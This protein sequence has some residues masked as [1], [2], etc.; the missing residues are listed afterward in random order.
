MTMPPE[1]QQSP[2]DGKE[3]QAWKNKKK[4]KNKKQGQGQGQGQEGEEVQ[5]QGQSPSPT[6]SQKKGQVNGM[7]HH[8]SSNG[9]K[10]QIA[11]SP[12]SAPSPVASAS[13]S[14]TPT[15]A[16]PTE[17]IVNSVDAPLSKSAA[18]RQRK[19]AKIATAKQGQAHSNGASDHEQQSAQQK[20]G[21]QPSARPIS[22]PAAAD[23]VKPS[24][25]QQQPPKGSTSNSQPQASKERKEMENKPTPQTARPA[26]SAVSASQ[27]VA[28]TSSTTSPAPSIPSIRLSQ[29]T[30]PMSSCASVRPAFASHSL[31]TANAYVDMLVNWLRD[32]A[33]L[34]PDRL[35]HHHSH[36]HAI[37]KCYVVEMSAGLNHGKF[38]YQFMMQLSERVRELPMAGEM[39]SVDPNVRSSPAALLAPLSSHFTYVL[40]DPDQSRLDNLRLHP[41]LQALMEMGLMDV[42]RLDPTNPRAFVIAAPAALAAGAQQQIGVE[43]HLQHSGT[44]LT[45]LDAT[46]PLLCICNEQM[47]LGQPAVTSTAAP[48]A[49]K[50][51]KG[52]LHA[53]VGSCPWKF[54]GFAFEQSSSGD[55]AKDTLTEW[56]VHVEPHEQHVYPNV[57]WQQKSIAD[58]STYYSTPE[59]NRVLQ[60]AVQRLKQVQLPHVAVNPSFPAQPVFVD[61]LPPRSTSSNSSTPSSQ[62]FTLPITAFELLRSLR[63]FARGPLLL[64]MA[65][66]AFTELVTLPAQKPSVGFMR[67][68][69]HTAPHPMPP[70]VPNMHSLTWLA[71]EMGGYALT[72][73]NRSVS[74]LKLVAVGFTAAPDASNDDN[75]DTD[76]VILPVP[77]LTTSPSKSLLKSP[78]DSS[79]PNSG[80][81]AKKHVQFCGLS[82][83]EQKLLRKAEKARRQERLAVAQKLAAERSSGRPRF[84][85]APVQLRSA[86]HRHFCI[87]SAFDL[88]NVVSLCLPSV[89]ISEN[90]AAAAD[91]RLLQSGL[92]LLALAQHDPEIW[93]KLKAIFSAPVPKQKGSN[94]QQKQETK[95]NDAAATSTSTSSSESVTSTAPTYFLSSPMEHDLFLALTRVWRNFFALPSDIYGTLSGQQNV[96]LAF[97]LGS[98]YCIRR[99]FRTAIAY[100]MRSLAWFGRHAVTLFNLA[101][102]HIHLREYDAA[103][104]LMKE[105]LQL[106]PHGTQAQEWMKWLDC[107]SSTT[108]AATSASAMD[109][110]DVDKIDAFTETPGELEDD[111]ERQ[112][113][114][115]HQQQQQKVQDAQRH[116]EQTQAVNASHSVSAIATDAATDNA[117]SNGSVAIAAQPAQPP[118]EQQQKQLPRKQPFWEKRKQLKEARKAAAAAASTSSGPAHTGSSTVAASPSTSTQPSSASAQ[119]SV[120]STVSSTVGPKMKQYLQAN[121]P[122]KESWAEAEDDDDDTGM[123]TVTSRLINGKHDQAQQPN[124]QVSKPSKRKHKARNNDKQ[125]AGVVDGPNPSSASA[126]GAA[127]PSSSPSSS[128][129]PSRPAHPPHP[130]SSSSLPS[131]T[132]RQ[133]QP[134]TNS[135]PTHNTQQHQHQH[136]TNGKQQQQK[137]NRKHQHKASK[138]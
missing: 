42:A 89:S 90:V 128:T 22:A 121:A 24:K 116:Q 114:Q 133:N 38:A 4:K 40:T 77:A 71:E 112:S 12:T 64:L 1:V 11:L 5:A 6:N 51:V 47:T 7:V 62:T 111:E 78:S 88:S 10:A 2:V 75:D 59:F 135:H 95:A 25:Q 130:S 61:S 120:P 96:D 107:Q 49:R 41:Q 136:S 46:T 115:P 53:T 101:L 76:D 118:A 91:A 81:L 73:Q 97:E 117:N 30:L 98:F 110:L 29:S 48:R 37:N 16:P 134:N 8:A 129:L 124:G 104:A 17:P 119:V 23:H 21:V 55:A 56:L 28:S 113:Q 68:G 106:D 138:Q 67:K 36:S 69:L 85:Q 19:A 86:F 100:Y 65:D 94:K 45:R 39:D 99:R 74:T 87:S 84:M 132:P 26:T 70:N 31:Q 9:G 44:L 127:S 123:A 18:K 83:R 93:L 13:P 15:P 108:S 60:R 109:M 80:D 43:L 125:H 131:T 52:G 14:S 63:A 79:T 34:S 32:A 103:R 3:K 58:P 20:N 33:G 105:S 66:R 92:S 35:H 82:F 54:D 57:E 102:C 27:S 50:G 126:A 137:Q 72:Q 122:G